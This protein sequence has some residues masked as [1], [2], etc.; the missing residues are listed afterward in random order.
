MNDWHDD[1]EPL[2]RGTVRLLRENGFNTESS[3]GHKMSVQCQYLTDG[4]LQRLDCLLY[5]NGY[6]NYIIEAFIKRA[7][8][9][10]YT[11]IEIKG[12]VLP[13]TQEEEE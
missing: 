13:N 11:G 4:E 5:E 2:I 6:R 7:D 1:I 9:H 3:C 12:I 8:G 10:Q